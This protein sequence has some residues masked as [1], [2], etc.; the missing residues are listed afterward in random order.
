MVKLNLTFLS[1]AGGFILLTGCS[2][3]SQ[4]S[5]NLSE[6]KV[7]EIVAN[8]AAM[9]NNKI[10][11]ER[12][13]IEVWDKGNIEVADEILAPNWIDHSNSAEVPEGVTHRQH[14]KEVVAGFKDV[15]PNSRFKIEQLLADGEMVI[16][17][18]S[19]TAKQEKDYF[20]IRPTGKTKRLGGIDIYH[21]RD[22]QMIEEWETH[23]ELGEF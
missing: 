6:E 13:F 7:I 16:L 3:S 8:E 2:D 12:Y 4:L 10:L 22:G 11:A 18:F 5:N 23:E 21:F 9:E 19:A 15:F 1:V 14:L 17:R 20:G